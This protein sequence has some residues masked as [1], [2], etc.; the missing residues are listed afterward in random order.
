MNKFLQKEI[1]PEASM[2]LDLIRAL[3]AIAVAMSHIRGLFFVDYKNVK[4]VTIFDRIF[5][6]LT[7]F[8]HPAV[9]VFFG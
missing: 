7:G 5:Y 1:T 4:H 2:H 9:I 8:G 6:F 3:A